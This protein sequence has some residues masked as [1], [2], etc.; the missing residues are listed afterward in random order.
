MLPLVQ[1]M[2]VFMP[3]VIDTGIGLPIVFCFQILIC[4]IER[5][6]ATNAH[7]KQ[8]LGTYLLQKR[9]FEKV[10]VHYKCIAHMYKP[11]I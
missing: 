4:N 3:Y 8:L 6:M 9:E 2:P 10:Y 11:Y 1:N 7:L 5:E